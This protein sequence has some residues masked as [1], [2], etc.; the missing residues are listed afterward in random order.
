MPRISIE[1]KHTYNTTPQRTLTTVFSAEGP[2]FIPVINQ[3]VYPISGTDENN[4]IGRKISTSSIMSEGYIYLNDQ[5]GYSNPI[6]GVTT[7]F[8]QAYYG[9]PDQLQSNGQSVPGYLG[10]K[11]VALNLDVENSFSY[12]YNPSMDPWNISIRHLVIE[13]DDSTFSQL[14]LVEQWDYIRNWYQNLVIQTS[15]LELS[16]N[17]MQILRESTPYTGTF[18]I[19]YDKTHHL[20]PSNRVLHYSYTIPYKRTL[21]FESQ[22]AEIPTNKYVI[23]VFIPPSNYKIDFGSVGFGNYLFNTQLSFSSGNLSID[24]AYINSTLK[25]KYTDI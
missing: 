20:T 9:V 25:L 6:S 22:G 10:R 5:A 24:S 14:G 4:R 17:T 15:N 3:L 16:S 12:H 23:E 1:D 7:S 21:N 19:L 8:Y 18:K 13:F 2:F 11:S